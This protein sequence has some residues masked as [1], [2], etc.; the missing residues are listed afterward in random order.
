VDQLGDCLGDRSCNFVLAAEKRLALRIGRS[1]SK[2]IPDRSVAICWP[3]I[4]YEITEVENSEEALAA[5]Q[6]NG[7]TSS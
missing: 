1:H 5:K 6:N 7:P 4:D 3:P 2:C